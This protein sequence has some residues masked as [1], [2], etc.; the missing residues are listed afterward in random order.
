MEGN[1]EAE[2]RK[3]VNYGMESEFQKEVFLEGSEFPADCALKITRNSNR[4]DGP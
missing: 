4:F 3:G 2:L 1:S